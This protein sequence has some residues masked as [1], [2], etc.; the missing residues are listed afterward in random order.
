MF[1]CVC[2]KE[3][4]QPGF[5][6]IIHGCNQDSCTRCRLNW[7]KNRTAFEKKKYIKKKMEERKR[8][9]NAANISLALKVVEDKVW[10]SRRS[11]SLDD[12]ANVKFLND[13]L[14]EKNLFFFLVACIL[15]M[16]IFLLCSRWIFVNSCLANGDS[17]QISTEK[18]CFK[19]KNLGL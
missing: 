2:K 14:R 7:K 9:K 10:I 11:S 19:T 8:G 5:G 17:K 6:I 4:N 3:R 1:V 18:K 13:I 15:N 12:G 16:V